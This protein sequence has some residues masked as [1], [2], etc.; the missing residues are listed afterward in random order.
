[1]P[2]SL[3]GNESTF[4]RGRPPAQQSRRPAASNGPG[5]VI[6][7][8][9][10]NFV[11][12]IAGS[13]VGLISGVILAVL[14]GPSDYGYLALVMSVL[15]VLVIGSALGFE[16]A[17][18]KYIPLLLAERKSSGIMRL[19][20]S[21]TLI[22]VAIAVALSVFIFLTADLLAD[23][24]F[25]K[26]DLAIYLRVLTLMVVPYSLESI[27]RGLL[28]GFYQQ[29][30]INL[31]DAGT[32]TL[33][34][35]LAAAVLLRGYGVFGVLFV[36]L[37]IQI[38]FVTL[39]A[40]RGLAL[41]PPGQLAGEPPEMGKVLRFSLYLYLFTIMNFV[42][43][44][45]LDVMMIGGM[46]SDIRQVGYYNI[47]F[48]FAYMS[49]SFFS[50]VLGGGIT[51]TYFSELYARKDFK[52]LRRGYTALV[53]YMFVYIIPMAIVG[54]VLAKPLIHL[55][56]GAQY[57][58]T[59]AVEL[60]ALYFPVMAFL[61]FGGVT[62]TFM[63]AMDQEKKLVIS[64]T[65]FGGTNIVLNFLLIPSLLAFG[66]LIG[67]GVASIAGL[68]YESYVVHKCLHPRY[69]YRFLGRML[70]LSLCSGLAAYVLR[71]LMEP[72]AAAAGLGLQGTS[73]L[74]LGG[75]GLPW[76]GLTLAIFVLLKPLSPETADVIE[77]VPIPFK[78]FVMR[79][80]RQPGKS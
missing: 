76:L 41:I 67:T 16:F 66:A 50:L 51:L 2:A 40:R 21:F 73:L 39:A 11:G 28:T 45:Q 43:G 27:Y 30:F 65:I 48:T 61:K 1:M 64:R 70:A 32:K 7:G 46:V 60:L 31:L 29:K 19:V 37:L 36:N 77:K 24:V 38:L 68:A 26:P 52:S 34:L 13:A 71:L 9:G 75:A 20:R 15:N 6:S 56:F 10:W 8:I 23:S 33:Y 47:A 72:V 78:K 42:L 74:V 44:Q 5:K 57:A 62:S 22:K 3:P 79:L 4:G 14:L 54:A 55:I 49:L 58:G 63:S 69:P 53:E 25:R 80:I 35:V 17:L 12:I 59:A 18:N